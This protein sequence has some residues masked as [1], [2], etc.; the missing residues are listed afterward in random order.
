LH[1]GYYLTLVIQQIWNG[2]LGMSISNFRGHSEKMLCCVFSN[3]DPNVVFSGGEDYCLL[4]WKIDAQKYQ[5]PPDE[6]KLHFIKNF[7]YYS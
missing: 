4:R 1:F 3:I 2:E 7:N 6:C 5:T